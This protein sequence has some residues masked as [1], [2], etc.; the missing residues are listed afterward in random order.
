MKAVARTIAEDGG[1]AIYLYHD[2]AVESAWEPVMQA[3]I[4][5]Y[6]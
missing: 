6:R 3:T 4:D 1:A 5:R 2:V